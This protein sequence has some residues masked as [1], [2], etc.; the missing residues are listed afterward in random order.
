MIGCYPDVGR[1]ALDHRQNRSEHAAHGADVLAVRISRSEK[2][3][4]ILSVACAEPQ[5]VTAQI[6]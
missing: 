4:R 6:G 3:N 1:A 2:I 5:R